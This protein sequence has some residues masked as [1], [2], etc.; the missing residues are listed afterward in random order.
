MKPIDIF[1]AMDGIS[2][3]F[4]KETEQAVADHG[5]SRISAKQE[6]A[7]APAGNNTGEITAAGSSGVQKRHS[8]KEDT[9]MSSRQ[10]IIQRI[11][12]GIAAAA[13]CAVF[14]GGGWFIAQQAKQNQPGSANSLTEAGERNFLGGTG[15]IHVAVSKAYPAHGLELMY[16]DTK[17][18]F[19]NGK[20]AADRYGSFDSEAY[21][22]DAGVQETI[23]HTLYDGEQFYYQDGNCLYLMDNAG[24]TQAEPFYEISADFIAGTQN[25][26]DDMYIPE[27]ND[28]IPDIQII[29]L[30]KLRE[31][32][33]VVGITANIYEDG[34][35]IWTMQGNEVYRPQNEGT[36]RTWEK[37][38][39]IPGQ[40]ILVRDDLAVYQ[41]MGYGRYGRWDPNLPTGIPSGVDDPAMAEMLSST[42][43]TLGDGETTQPAEYGKAWCVHDNCIYYMTAA[44][45]DNVNYE[46]CHYASLDIY[47]GDFTDMGKMWF[48]AF[49]PLDDEILYV[50]RDGDSL[51]TDDYALSA[52]GALFSTRFYSDRHAFAS[53]KSLEAAD[54]T[55]A[56]IALEYT[57]GEDAD[58]DYLIYDRTAGEPRY[59]TLNRAAENTQEEPAQTEPA[60]QNDAVNAL[61]GSGTL[62]P[63]GWMNH[64][65]V[66]LLRDNDNYYYFDT[67]CWFECPLAGGQFTKITYPQNSDLP[68]TGYFSEQYPFPYDGFISDG[69]RIYTND[70]DIVSDGY[71]DNHFDPSAVQ[72][73][74]STLNA[75]AEPNG[76]YYHG[77]YIWHIRD[78][79][80]IVTGA[81]AIAG[82]AILGDLSDAKYEIWTD[83]SGSILSA[84]KAKDGTKRY[85]CSDDKREMY[86]IVNGEHDLV[87][88]PGYEQDDLPDPTAY[89]AIRDAYCVGDEEYY[90]TYDNELYTR[91]NGQ[92]VLIDGEQQ[93][94]GW[95][96]LAPDRRFFY[97]E[98]D[99]SGDALLEWKGGEKTLIYQPGNDEFLYFGGFE[100]NETGGYNIILFQHDRKAQESGFVFIDAAT[101]ETVK[102]L[103][104]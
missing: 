16:D 25:L 84:E 66:S 13:A 87:E 85:Y 6:T 90:V 29:N 65:Y 91:V 52:S 95:M 30:Q 41:A 68:Y 103:S 88:C 92:P 37:A 58:F 18:Y 94:G 47:T 26:P 104:Q 1:D 69:E 36:A 56:L 82:A 45:S 78:R 89:G 80:F 76:W 32:E 55:Y 19:E 23:S 81:N 12:T 11:T 93:Y 74:L 100:P 102:E 14:A 63:V 96:Q 31:N 4:I 24:N 38:P 5:E 67:S 34:E 77:K 51:C 21:E 60:P 70:L 46:P 86:A 71:A 79:Y 7:D 53:L 59:F 99:D 62:Y 61:G 57:G 20:Y 33:Y 73:Y 17:V 39:G 15:E 83:D 48:D 43:M 50:T 98:S 64:G 97:V 28:M 10:P 72:Q 42:L 2:E 44:F 54:E 49:I 22:T 75:D 40:I 101:C 3:K 27:G 35:P 9:G 8:R